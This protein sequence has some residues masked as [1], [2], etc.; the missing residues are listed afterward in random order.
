MSLMLHVLDL[1][2]YSLRFTVGALIAGWL[3]VTPPGY[4]KLQ[5]EMDEGS[6]VSGDSFYIRL[7]LNVG[8]S[9]NCT[10]SA[11][12]D[13]VVHVL[14]TMY[15]GKHEWLCARVDGV[16]DKDLERGTIPSYSR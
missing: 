4:R 3:P 5:R 8:P 1:L 16:T 10:L 6:V 11:R 9:D 15:N 14:D 7:N 2:G 13:E 12:C